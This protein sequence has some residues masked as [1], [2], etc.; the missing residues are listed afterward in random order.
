MRVPLCVCVCVCAC[1]RACVRACALRIV[2]RDK[3]LRFKNTLIIIIILYWV[4]SIHPVLSCVNSSCVELCQFILCWVVPIH[5]VLSCVSSSCVELCQFILCWVE[6]I[7]PVL[8]CVNSSCIELFN[9]SC[10]DGRKLQGSCGHHVHWPL[11]SAPLCEA[12]A[13]CVSL[14]AENKWR[15]VSHHTILYPAGDKGSKDRNL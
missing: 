14:C 10:A 4:V 6:S 5:P 12:P 15:A 7:H 9:S 11:S 8:S 1:V 2:S 3:I 13:V